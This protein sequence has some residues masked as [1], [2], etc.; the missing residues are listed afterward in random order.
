M[1]PWISEREE[2]G[3]ERKTSI[4]SIC[5]PTGIKPTTEVHTLDRESNLWPFSALANDLTTEPPA[6]AFLNTTF[7]IIVK[8]L[9]VN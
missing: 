2:G 4:A 7:Y 6:S 3:C 5:C 8:N 9:N 1:F